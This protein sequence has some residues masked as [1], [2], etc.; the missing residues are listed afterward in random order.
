VQ[1][2]SCQLNPVAYVK[3]DKQRQQARTRGEKSLVDWFV[4]NDSP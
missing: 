3:D 2:A 4:D 1:A